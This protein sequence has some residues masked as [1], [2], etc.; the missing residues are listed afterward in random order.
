MTKK[1]LLISIAVFLLHLSSFGQ[2]ACTP[3]PTYTNTTTQNGIYPDTIQNFD[4][5]YANT[6]YSQLVT[7][8]I[9]PD[10]SVCTWDSTRLDSVTGLPGSFS[11]ACW[12]N[13]GFGDP[14]R[15]MWKGNSIGCVIITGTPTNAEIGT[16]PLI[17]YT[18]NW[19]SGFFCPGGNQAV[20]IKGYR[21]VVMPSLVAVNESALGGQ[22]L[23]QNNPNPFADKTEINF[24]VEENGTAKFKIYNLI[25]DMIY[26]MDVK[27]KMGMNKID[28]DAKDFNSGIYFYSVVHGNTTFTR[29]MVVNK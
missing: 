11:Y 28:L 15:C 2:A 6:A 8:V 10:T 16:H 22:S 18:G 17:M 23:L 1:L 14:N 3:S 13:N 21:I 20:A 5:A 4:T 12:N 27:V 7:I 25:G 29:K 26:Q 24:T 19:V 9:P